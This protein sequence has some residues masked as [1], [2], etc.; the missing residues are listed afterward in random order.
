MEQYWRFL[1]INPLKQKYVSQFVC[2]C[3]LL[4]RNGRKIDKRFM[5]HIHVMY[6]QLDW[7]N[8]HAENS[9]SLYMIRMHTRRDVIMIGW[10]ERLMDV[11]Q[12]LEVQIPPS[13]GA[14]WK[15]SNE[16]MLVGSRR[17]WFASPPHF[18]WWNKECI[19]YLRHV[20][21]KCTYM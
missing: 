19:H 11:M 8:L 6:I 13:S 14:N 21:A 3:S 17:E 18:D 9:P 16:K 7:V 12:N 5:I 2:V 1:Q 20:Y 4:L 15:K 10:L